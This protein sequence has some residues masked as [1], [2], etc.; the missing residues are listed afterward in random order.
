MHARVYIHIHI[1]VYKYNIYTYTNVFYRRETCLM[2]D[3]WNSSHSWISFVTNMIMSHATHANE[4]CHTYEWVVS[5]AWMNRITCMNEE[6][7]TYEWV[8]SHLWMESCHTHISVPCHTYQCA[9]SQIWM[10]DHPPPPHTLLKDS[11]FNFGAKI[12]IYGAKIQ[13]TVKNFKCFTPKLKYVAPK[14]KYLTPNSNSWIFVPPKTSL[15]V[16]RKVPA[17]QVWHPPTPPSVL[18]TN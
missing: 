15:F 18:V 8:M 11:L 16:R 9:M 14:F 10:V 3:E 7:H 17:P 2:F 13:C 4:P 5:H 1:H 12:Q 6:C